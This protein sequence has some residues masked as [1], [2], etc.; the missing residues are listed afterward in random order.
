MR[1]VFH[2]VIRIIGIILLS[3]YIFLVFFNG[4]SSGQ[5]GGLAIAG[6]ILASFLVSILYLF[7]EA[8]IFSRKKLT[9]KS[10][11]N[12]ALGIILVLIIVCSLAALGR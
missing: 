5:W 7:I 2:I 6:A 12:L 4:D 11:A 3:V 8:Y 9:G 1:I 10:N